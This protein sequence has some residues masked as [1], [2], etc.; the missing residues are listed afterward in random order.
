MKKAKRPAKRRPPRLATVADLVRHAVRRFSR[1]RL[2]FAHGTP[3]PVAEA[4]FL[5]GEA[6]GIPP[7]RVEARARMRVPAVARDAA[8]ELIERRIRSRK[9]AAYLVNRIYMRG[10]PFYIDERAIVP[11]S[12]LGEI[13]DS[14]AFAGARFSLLP[15]FSRVRR[16]L[17]LCTGSGCLAV[18]AALQFPNAK[19]DAVDLSADALEVAA[20]NVAAHRLTRRIRLLQG[21][22]YGPVADQRYDVIVANPPYVDAAGMARLPPECRHEPPMAFDG[23]RDGLDLVRRIVDGAAAHLSR[24]GGLL[25]EIGRGRKALL[26]AYPDL[27]FLWL[28]TEDSIGEVFW[29]DAAALPQPAAA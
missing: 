15:D 29:L 20:R 19:V 12:Y 4:A 6:A 16:I 27:P 17:D 5:V 3:D 18:L 14:E 10:V 28:D 25:C 11:R 22:L 23:G 13:L 26:R 7:D 21:D 9:P 8:L 2:T 24:R 1:A